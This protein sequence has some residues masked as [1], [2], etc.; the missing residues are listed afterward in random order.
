MKS[1]IRTFP[2]Y[3]AYECDKIRVYLEEMA[4]KGWMLKSIGIGYTFTRA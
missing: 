2:G 3:R 1:A 4:Q